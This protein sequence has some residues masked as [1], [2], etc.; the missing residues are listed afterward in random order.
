[1]T[2]FAWYTG[3]KDSSEVTVKFQMFKSN[4]FYLYFIMVDFFQLIT[5]NR[6]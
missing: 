4:S 5:T 1:M 3:A 6:K 2:I